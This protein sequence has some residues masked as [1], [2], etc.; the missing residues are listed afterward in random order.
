MFILLELGLLNETDV[1]HLQ[2]NAGAAN[3]IEWKVK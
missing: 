1:E 2:L 3:Q